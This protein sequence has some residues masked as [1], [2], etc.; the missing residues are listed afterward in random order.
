MKAL[1]GDKIPDD[2]SCPITDEIFYDPVMTE[3]GSTYER[4]AITAWLEKYL[5]SPASHATL[6][7][8]KLIP[9]QTLKKLIRQFYENNKAL[10][11]K[12]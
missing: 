1:L 8:K 11:V 6:S 10:L 12:E 5:I 7:L 4:N 9:N 2:F 3:D